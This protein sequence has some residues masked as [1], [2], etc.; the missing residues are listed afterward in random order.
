MTDTNPSSAVTSPGVT[1]GTGSSRLVLG[2]FDS[3]HDLE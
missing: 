3:P 2:T 1:T